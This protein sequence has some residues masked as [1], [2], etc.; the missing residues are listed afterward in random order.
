MELLCPAPYLYWTDRFVRRRSSFFF[1]VCRDVYKHY[2]VLG[3]RGGGG[4]G[5]LAWSL[6]GCLFSACCFTHPAANQ[7]QVSIQCRSGWD[8]KRGRV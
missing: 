8:D 1:Y 2:A 4:S 3:K 6:I 7:A 5:W